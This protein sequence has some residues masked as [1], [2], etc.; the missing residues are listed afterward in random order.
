MDHHNAIIATLDA[1]FKQIEGKSNADYRPLYLAVSGKPDHA[2]V[3]TWVRGFGK[4]M[5]L[6]A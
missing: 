1:G 4:A 2:V 5:S 3:L 6:A